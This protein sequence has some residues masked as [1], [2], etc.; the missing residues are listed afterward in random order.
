MAQPSRETIPSKVTHNGPHIRTEPPIHWY[1]LTVGDI[2][3][4]DTMPPDD[5]HYD[6]EPDPRVTTALDLRGNCRV[7]TCVLDPETDYWFPT[8]NM[9]IT[10]D[11][12]IWDIVRRLTVFWAAWPV[13]DDGDVAVIHV[14]E[15]T[16]G[17]ILI[18][19]YFANEIEDG[20]DDETSE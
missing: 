3:Q 19:I 10:P 4:M 1:G 5:R 7:Q 17:R 13:L 18:A 15:I 16:N 12:T 2:R 11:L 20:D 8:L 6:G 9:A 14:D